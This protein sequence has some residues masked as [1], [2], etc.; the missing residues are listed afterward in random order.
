MDEAMWISAMLLIVIKQYGIHTVYIY[1][2]YHN[3]YHIV[4]TVLGI[5]LERLYTFLSSA[6]IQILRSVLYS[7][8]ALINHK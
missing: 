7:E 1:D 8:W 5:S 6:V 3:G 4:Y 2:K